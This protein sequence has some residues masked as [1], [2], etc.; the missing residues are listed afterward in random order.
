MPQQT[1]EYRSL[2]KAGRARR[3]GLGAA[4]FLAGVVVAVNAALL[5]AAAADGSWGA[6]RIGI[7]VGPVANAA[8]ALVALACT[9]L[10][11]GGRAGTSAVPHVVLS[12]LLPLA[13]TMVDLLVIFSMDLR[14]G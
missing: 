9:P 4:L 1:L 6:L 5:A 2:P 13:A 12:I 14:G 8:L 3:R 10:L 7:L 11:K